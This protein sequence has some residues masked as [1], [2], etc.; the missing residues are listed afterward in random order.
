MTPTHP[1]KVQSPFCSIGTPWG[2][3]K[4]ISDRWGIVYMDWIGLDD[5]AGPSIVKEHKYGS[6]IEV[7][8]REWG[9]QLKT[10]LWNGCY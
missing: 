7:V 9:M 10:L 8:E 3:K 5:R 2:G 1:S 4:T 6:N